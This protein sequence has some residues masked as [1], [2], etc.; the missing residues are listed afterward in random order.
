VSTR[1]AVLE[2]GRERLRVGRWRGDSQ[3]AILSPAGDG[4]LPST[5]FLQRCLSTLADEGYTSVVTSALTRYEQAPFLAAG[6][7]EQE[8]LRLQ[9]H[10]LHRV[11]PVRDVPLR[12]ALAGDHPAVL[13]V[14]TASFSTFWQ[15]DEFSL[16][17]AIDATPATLFRVVVDRYDRVIGYAIAGRTQRRGYLQRLAVHP[18]HQGEGLGSALVADG[19]RWMRRRGVERG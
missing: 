9:S 12:R 15:L 14:D 1:S 18:A 5:S 6:F 19:L 11:P 13:A 4:A 3:I 8:Q 2:W 7:R 16:Q 10:D 17:E